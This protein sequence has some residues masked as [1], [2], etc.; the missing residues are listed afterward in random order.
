MLAELK[1]NWRTFEKAAPGSR[2]RKLYEARKKSSGVAAFVTLAAGVL[3]VA[4]GVVLLFIPGPGLLLIV[5]GGALI[6]QRSLWLAERLD[7][8]EPPLRRLVAQAKVSWKKASIAIRGAFIGS[9]AIV[10]AGA[11]YAAYL[12]M[13]K[14]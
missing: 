2:F 13:F 11:A 14:N 6:A 1:K 12:W 3:L 8:L 9:A 7:R 4:G 10:A 5:F